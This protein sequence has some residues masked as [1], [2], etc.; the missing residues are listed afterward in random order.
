MRTLLVLATLC[1]VVGAASPSISW[2][3]KSDRGFDQ[4]MEQSKFVLQVFVKPKCAECVVLDR[5]SFKDRDVLELL[6]EKFVAI[7]SDMAKTDGRT[8]AENYGIEVFPT[9]LFF[10]AKGQQIESATLTGQ[11][12]ADE[13]FQHLVNVS[14][15]KFDRA[16]G[17]AL[18]STTG[19]ATTA[20]APSTS[21]WSRPDTSATIAPPPLPDTAAP[22]I[23]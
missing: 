15:G 11:L 9:I 18:I 23:P 7:R 14:T 5:T 8:D 21:G 19:Q 20:T 1:T 3:P 2:A 16:A 17:P 10:N 6:A 12:G 4:A 22:A 13:F